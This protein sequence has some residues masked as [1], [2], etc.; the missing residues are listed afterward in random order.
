LIGPANATC[1]TQTENCN[2]KELEHCMSFSESDVSNISH[3][4]YINNKNETERT[5]RK[6][7]KE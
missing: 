7:E 2:I 1:I 6:I 3:I 4:I 5:K